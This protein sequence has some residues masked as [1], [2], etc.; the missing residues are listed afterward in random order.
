MFQS[1]LCWNVVSDRNWPAPSRSATASFNPSYAGMW[2]V[3][4]QE[5]DRYKALY[6]FQSFLCWNVVSDIR[7]D[8]SKKGA[9]LVSI[10]LMLECGQ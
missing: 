7:T 1:F 4:E 5:R 9:I 8:G 6:E 10:L 2:S 3:T